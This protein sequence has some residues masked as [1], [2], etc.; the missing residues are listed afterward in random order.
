MQRGSYSAVHAAENLRIRDSK[1][2]H[3]RVCAMLQLTHQ[4]STEQID[5]VECS[6]DGA[7]EPFLYHLFHMSDFGLH[8]S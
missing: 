4:T 7:E 5:I 6:A 2:I 1:V 8:L 3:W